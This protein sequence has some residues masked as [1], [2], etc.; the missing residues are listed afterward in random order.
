MALMVTSALESAD[1]KSVKLRRQHIECSYMLFDMVRVQD[2]R[3][4]IPG[5]IL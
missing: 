3:R 2:W 5:T 1:A 4:S